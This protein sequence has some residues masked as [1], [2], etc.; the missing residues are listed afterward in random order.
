M[1]DVHAAD[2]RR[3][4]RTFQCLCFKLG[5]LYHYLMTETG[6]APAAISDGRI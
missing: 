1:A 5:D 4:P 2:P 6:A 3:Q